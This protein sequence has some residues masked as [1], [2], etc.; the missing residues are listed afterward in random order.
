M[1]K[2]WED[3]ASNRP[4]AVGLKW[5][6]AP[7][8]LPAIP[9]GA[10]GLVV[11]DCDRKPN[12]VD[13]VTAFDAL[14]IEQDIDLSRAFVIETPSG[15]LHFYFS[16]QTPYS[17]SR[18]SL[19]AGI[20]VRGAGGYVIAAGAVLPDGRRYR[21]VAGSWDAMLPPLPEALAA[22]LKEETCFHTSRS[23]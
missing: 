11:I 19:P 17:N 13:G 12:G 16:T 4:F 18:G 5:D 14:C 15:G 3:A 22:F 20:D 7:D 1:V 21:H 8:A 9:V 6:A 23:F 10:H 2:D